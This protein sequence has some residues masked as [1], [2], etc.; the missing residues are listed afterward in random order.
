[1]ATFDG[2]VS[3]GDEEVHVVL[4]VRDDETTLSS[5]GV[6]I[7]TW[8]TGEVTITYVGQGTYFITAEDETLEFV[9][10]DQD[11]FAIRFGEVSDSPTVSETGGAGRHARVTPDGLAAGPSKSR[12][13]EAPPPQT[14]TKAAFYMLVGVT[15][16]LA[17]WAVY[18][19]IFG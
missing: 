1:M 13:G 19:M 8:P 6:E 3:L 12:P 7:G 11:L 4:V 15:A 2:F 17:L 14:M 16:F 10:S 5:D 9:P 18:S